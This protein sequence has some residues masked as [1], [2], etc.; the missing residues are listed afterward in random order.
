M[1]LEEEGVENA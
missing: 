1:G